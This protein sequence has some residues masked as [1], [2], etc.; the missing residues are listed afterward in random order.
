MKNIGIVFFSPTGSTRAVCEEISSGMGIKEPAIVDITKPETRENIVSG[1]IDLNSFDHLIVGAP[2]YCGKLPL[3]VIECLSKIN[4]EETAATAVVV[5]GNRDFGVSLH[6]LV[7]L[8]TDSG[9]YVNSAGIFIGEHSYSEIVPIAVNRPDH[10]DLSKARDF[11]ESIL[12]LNG[13]SVSNI[14]IQLD[15]IS[16]SEKYTSIKP[17]FRLDKCN[18]CGICAAV[19]PTGIISTETGSYTTAETEKSC[20]GCMACVRKCPT[21]ARTS[22]V[23]PMI[24]IVMRQMFKEASM[25]RKEPFTIIS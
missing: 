25:N 13:R 2:V 14:P 3:Q 8:L 21:E 4:I 24:R 1:R 18:N 20:V 23:N 19:C 15:R 22:K 7:A 16:R 6:T 17:Y 10:D 11:G 9:C 12:S 5:Y